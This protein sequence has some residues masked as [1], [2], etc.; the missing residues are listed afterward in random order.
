MKLVGRSNKHWTFFNRSILPSIG[1][2]R[3]KI[4][5]A[6]IWLWS[7]QHQSKRT[8]DFFY[9]D[10]KNK[11]QS[12]FNMLKGKM[13]ADQ[14]PMNSTSKGDLIAKKHFQA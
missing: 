3:F 10:E 9:V 12:E 14:M 2:I 4:K 1:N 11:F 7:R 6:L 8:G 5:S 13:F